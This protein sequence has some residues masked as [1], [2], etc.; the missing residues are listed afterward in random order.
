MVLWLLAKSKSEPQ[1][2]TYTAVH[3]SIFYSASKLVTVYSS[4]SHESTVY[5]EFYRE[6]P[7]YYNY[8]ASSANVW[9]KAMGL[10]VYK[11]SHQRIET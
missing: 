7:Q 10:P 1:M 4:G 8:I 11:E 2:G 9:S 5:G 3:T 6:I